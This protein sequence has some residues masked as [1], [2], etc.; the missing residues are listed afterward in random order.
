MFG[1]LFALD[2]CDLSF[3]R[4]AI[5]RLASEVAR[6]LDDPLP[7]HEFQLQN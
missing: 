6:I 7:C 3:S 2:Q 4:F 5:A 1:N